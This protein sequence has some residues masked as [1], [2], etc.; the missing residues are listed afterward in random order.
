MIKEERES[1]RKGYKKRIKK[2]LR[3]IG[4]GSIYKKRY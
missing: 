3:G 2:I 1:R 4:H